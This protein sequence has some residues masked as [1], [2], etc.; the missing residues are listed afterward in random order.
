MITIVGLLSLGIILLLILPLI[1]AYS[2]GGG[3][4]RSPLDYLDN[5]WVIFAI[6]FMI[7]FAVI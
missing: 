5:E 3:Y 2:W 4:Y 1:S 7:F 6:I